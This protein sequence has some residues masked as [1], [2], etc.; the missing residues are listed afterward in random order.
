MEMEESDA[1]ELM[2]N[3]SNDAVIFAKSEFGTVLDYSPQSMIKIE[4]LIIE[5]RENFQSDIAQEKVLY[6]LSN[7]LGAYC[8]ECFIRQH[9]GSWLIEDDGEK[10]MV[11]LQAGEF[12][13]PFPGVVYLNLVDR[14]SLS[15][16]DYYREASVKL[17]A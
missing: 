7:I 8:G 16:N 6:T 15:I 10:N 1:Q 12:T 11:Y 17:G 9:G 4:H 2:K 5:L 3:L 14:D 13:F